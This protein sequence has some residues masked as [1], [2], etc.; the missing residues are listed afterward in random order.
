MS[1]G[2]SCTA[3]ALTRHTAPRKVLSSPR[4]QDHRFC[5]LAGL[6]RPPT[7]KLPS[8]CQHTGK[9]LTQVCFGS[10]SVFKVC[11]QLLSKSSNVVSRQ[12]MWGS[13]LRNVYAHDEKAKETPPLCCLPNLPPVQPSYQW[14]SHF[15]TNWGSIFS[16]FLI[17]PVYYLN[18]QPVISP[19]DWFFSLLCEKTFSLHSHGQPPQDRPLSPDQRQLASLQLLPLLPPNVLLLIFLEYFYYDIHFSRIYW[20]WNILGIFLKIFFEQVIYT[21]DIKFRRPE[22][23]FSEK[24]LRS[25]PLKNQRYQFLC[26]SMNHSRDS[27]CPYLYAC[28]KAQAYILYTQRNHSGDVT[29][30]FYTLFFPLNAFYNLFHRK[31]E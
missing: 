28:I 7:L 4:S 20:R 22:R 24:S 17:L 30:K 12:K 26:L 31:Y 13:K 29:K 18:I 5:K 19:V 1:L 15:L 21:H 10:C 16:S 23:E 14:T 8:W 25:L 2:T 27:L 6:H 9:T 11:G 3:R